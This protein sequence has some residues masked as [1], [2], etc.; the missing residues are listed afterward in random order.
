MSR[1]LLVSIAVVWWFSGCTGEAGLRCEN[2]ERYLGSEEIAPLQ[3]PDDL[4]APE[5][6]E[7]L[8]VPQAGGSVEEA[9]IPTDGPC[10]ESPP[11]FFEEGLPG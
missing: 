2:Q 3:V 1:R 10:T 8:R 7:A 6:A 11:D 9:N 5:D 4:D